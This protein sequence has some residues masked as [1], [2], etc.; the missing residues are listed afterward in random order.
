MHSV[1][2]IDGVLDFFRAARAL[3]LTQ[4]N[5]QEQLTGAVLEKMTILKVEHVLTWQQNVN[6]GNMSD[7]LVGVI[8]LLYNTSG[9]DQFIV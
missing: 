1:T 2:E 3:F 8:N 5:N 9:C 6:A 4:R 7:T